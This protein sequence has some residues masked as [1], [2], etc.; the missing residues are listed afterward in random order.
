MRREEPSGAGP[1]WGVASVNQEGL[2]H[3][4]FRLPGPPTGLPEFWP[5][6]LWERHLLLPLFL[7]RKTMR[8]PGFFLACCRASVSS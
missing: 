7:N 4:G 2:A 3:E 6:D 8:T 1:G 5:Q